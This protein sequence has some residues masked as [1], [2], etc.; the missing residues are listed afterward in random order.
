MIDHKSTKEDENDNDNAIKSLKHITG[1]K[2]IVELDFYFLAI[3]QILVI[4]LD[5][6]W[7]VL[8]ITFEDVIQATYWIVH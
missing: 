7:Q 8:E 4:W 6:C 5:Y 2:F 3:D 1:H